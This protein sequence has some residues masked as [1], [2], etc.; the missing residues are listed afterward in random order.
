MMTKQQRKTG[1]YILTYL[2][3]LIALLVL[4]HADAVDRLQLL[5]GTGCDLQRKG[6]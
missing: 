2:I 1:R 6:R 5:Q 4:S 3:C